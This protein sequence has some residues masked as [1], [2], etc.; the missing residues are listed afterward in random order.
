MQLLM[1]LSALAGFALLAWLLWQHGEAPL[2]AL[3]GVGFGIVP[4]IL[5][6]ILQLWCSGAAWHAVAET[7]VVIPRRTYVWTRWI[8]E[9]V[10][11]LLPVAQLGG[12]VI[13]ARLLV[14]TG[15][16]ATEAAAST[17]V[18]LTVEALTLVVFILIGLGFA[19]LTGT[20]QGLVGYTLLGLAAFV[21]AVFMLLLLQR[22]GLAAL[23]DRMANWLERRWP[24]L[25]VD[26]LRAMPAAFEACYR[27]P[28]GLALG[29]FWHLLGWLGGVIEIYVMGL[30]L[31][32]HVSLGQALVI[33]SLGQAI[34]GAA[35]FVPAGLGVQEGSLLWLATELGLPASAGLSLALLKRVRELA[36]G[37]PALLAWH[38]IESGR[39]SRF[40]R[41]VAGSSGP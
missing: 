27:N 10:G 5:F 22:R 1:R 23:L 26:G 3:L 30:V 2:H 6:H 31:D 35:F 14:L 13:G 41:P 33:E 25:K 34:R 9:A 36:L 20:G 8:R 29:C 7:A 40:R 19:V 17:T 16:R 4:V 28:R 21:P 37:L 18:D 39:W 12:E 32:L 11:G 38:A 24:S 15:A